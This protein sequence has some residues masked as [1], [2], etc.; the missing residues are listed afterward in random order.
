MRGGD[1]L[2][3]QRIA[4]FQ[5]LRREIVD[6]RHSVKMT[7]QNHTVLPAERSAGNQRVAVATNRQMWLP[8]KERLD[9]IGERPFLIADGKDVHDLVH[10]GVQRFLLARSGI[11]SNLIFAHASHYP[12]KRACVRHTDTVLR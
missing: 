12:P 2:T 6:N 8:L 4:W 1:I 3:N 7:G 5:P 10:Q 11:K 9:R